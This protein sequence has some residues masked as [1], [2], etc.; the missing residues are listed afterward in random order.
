MSGRGVGLDAVHEMVKAVRGTVRIQTEPGRGTRFMLQL[1]LTLSVIRSLLVDV[2]G[3][4]YA[5]PLAYVRRTLELARTEIDM[6]E[7]QQH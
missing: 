6:L 4:A 3:E 7:G 1:P 2:G 5:F